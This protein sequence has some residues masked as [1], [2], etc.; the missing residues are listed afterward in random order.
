MFNTLYYI[1]SD[2]NIIINRYINENF[3]N[4]E[5][6][7]LRYE[8]IK[9]DNEFKILQLKYNKLLNSNI[10]KDNE[11]K[12]LQQ[13]YN[14]LLNSNIKFELNNKIK[15]KDNNI[16]IN[17]TIKN[18]PDIKYSKNISTLDVILDTEN[19]SDEYENIENIENIEEKKQCTKPTID[20]PFMNVTMK[21]YLNI[22]D[23]KIV[24]RP[25]ACDT[26]DPEIKKEIDIMFKNNLFQ[27]IDD[28][29]EK[30]NS[31]RQFYTTASTT[32]P[33]DRDSFQKWLYASSKTCKQDQ[34]NCYRYE[35]IRAN[36]PVQYNENENPK[37]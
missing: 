32:I 3:N 37:R 7:K 30:F 14:K 23:G 21:D 22:K 27:D 13:T 6:K 19:S 24:D 10:K 2:D 16:T 26:T 11:L 15:H 9:K 31:Q 28:L 36:R 4:I 17:S 8:L 1:F 5:I 12:M 25:P 34:E 33:N 29:F 18:K 20:N 35:D